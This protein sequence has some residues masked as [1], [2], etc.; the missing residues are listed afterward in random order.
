MTKP[1]FFISLGLALAAGL[2]FLLRP[3]PISDST[4]DPAAPAAAPSA[5]A[6]PR[7][8]V[9]IE[10]AN[11][12]RTA[13]PERIVARR[14]A[15]VALKVTSDRA[16]TLHLHGYDLHAELRAGQPAAIV[17]TATH[18]GRFT[19]ELHESHLELGTLEVTP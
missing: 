14:G 2:F 7:V 9:T 19:Y 1:L 5:P 12:Q 4:P 16:D 15:E 3:V 17:F 13:G 6:L 8:E 10:V 11:G 18:T